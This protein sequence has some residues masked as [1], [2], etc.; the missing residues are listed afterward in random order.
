[1]VGYVDCPY[2]DEETMVT[3]EEHSSGKAEV[4]E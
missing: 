4:K 2:C 3:F 1:M